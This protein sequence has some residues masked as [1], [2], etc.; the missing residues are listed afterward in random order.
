MFEP[1]V[2]CDDGFENVEK[3]GK[4]IGFQL[5]TRIAY[6]RGVPLSMVESIK[7]EVDD[8]PVPSQNIRFSVGDETFTLAEMETVT[9]TKWE[10]GQKA[11]IFVDQP[12]GLKRGDHKVFLSQ[13]TRVAYY[14]FPLEG[15]RTRIMAIA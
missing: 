13:T 4:V 15:R 2:I 9:N 10:F 14:P 1:Y 5:Q 12:G 11:T 7:L 6:Y 3:E 8:K